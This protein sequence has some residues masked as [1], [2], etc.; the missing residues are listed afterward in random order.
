MTWET[1]IQEIHRREEL[2]KQMGGE[3]RVA[4]HKSRGKLTVRIELLVTRR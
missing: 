4:K 2:A 1:E 3:E